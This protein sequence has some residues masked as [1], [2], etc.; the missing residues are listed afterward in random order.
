MRSCGVSLG[1]TDPNGPA[2]EGAGRVG[3]ARRKRGVRSRRLALGLLSAFV[4]LA[5]SGAPR[6]EVSRYR[7]P[8]EVAFSP[9][10]RM[11]AVTD[12]TAGEVVL[13]DARTGRAT[14][15]AAVSPDSGGLAWQREGNRLWV[16]ERLRGTL[17]AVDGASGCVLR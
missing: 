11:L 10:G 17:A 12:A 8:R 6:S 1:D 5:A 13:V 7:S 15:R 16:A 3:A 9:D 4:I 2:S 14:R